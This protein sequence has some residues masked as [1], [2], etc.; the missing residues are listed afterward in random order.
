MTQ[1]LDET[2][3]K[4]E[5]VQSME[6]RGGV[7]P[8]AELPLHLWG[9]ACFSVYWITIELLVEKSLSISVKQFNQ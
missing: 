2:K 9:L 3:L 8:V 4:S 7:T 1:N 5:F 6:M